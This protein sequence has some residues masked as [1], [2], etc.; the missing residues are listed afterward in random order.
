MNDARAFTDYRPQ[1]MRETRLLSGEEAT[2]ANEYDYRMY[3]TRNA[4]KLIEEQRQN[5]LKVY[6][7]PPC[8][9]PEMYGTMLPEKSVQKCNEDNCSTYQVDSRGLGQGRNYNIKRSN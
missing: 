4:D 8:Y 2:F 1:C 6:E 7:C 3:L 5:A 9:R